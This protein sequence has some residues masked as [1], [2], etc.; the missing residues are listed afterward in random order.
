TL[1][2][3]AI[4]IN[5]RTFSAP[6]AVTYALQQEQRAVVVGSRSSGGANMMDDAASLPSGFRLGVPIHRPIG[7]LTGTNWEGIGVQPD[8][9]TSGDATLWRAWEIVRQR[10][11]DAG[12]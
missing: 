11:A 1:R 7:R 9:V 10:L 2:P 6:E 3:V 4:M 12:S 5:H 8:E